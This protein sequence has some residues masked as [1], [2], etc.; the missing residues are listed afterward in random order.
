MRLDRE[1]RRDESRQRLGE[2]S[3]LLAAAPASARVNALRQEVAALHEIDVDYDEMTL[4]RVESDAFRRS[5]K[6][7]S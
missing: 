7:E 4:K 6:H 2:A 3:K 5:R 1:G